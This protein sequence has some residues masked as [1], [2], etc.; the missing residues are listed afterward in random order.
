MAKQTARK[1]SG[2]A[3]ARQFGRLKRCNQALQNWLGRV[4]RDIDRQRGN[5]ALSANFTKLI[6][7]AEKI[8][9]Q[10]RNTPKKIYSLHESEVCCMGKGKDRVRYEFGQKVAVVIT[11]KGN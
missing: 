11:N 9:L 2:Y 10:E 5:K 7:V 6:E 1:A 4:L 3:S 8:R